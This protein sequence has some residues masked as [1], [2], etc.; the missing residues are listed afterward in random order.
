MTCSHALGITECLLK[1]AHDFDVNSLGP[2]NVGYAVTHHT[3]S[4][5]ANLSLWTDNIEPSSVRSL[6]W[7][8]YANLTPSTL[9]TPE[10]KKTGTGFDFMITERVSGD[11]FRGVTNTMAFVVLFLYAATVFIHLIYHTPW[12]RLE[13]Q[14]LEKSGFILRFRSAIASAHICAR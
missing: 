7:I 14:S 9:S 12:L 4:P 8:L 11:S 10:L 5:L 13:Q 6:Q 3:C 2:M 1:V